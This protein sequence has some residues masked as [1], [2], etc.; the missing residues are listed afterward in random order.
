MYVCQ[1]WCQKKCNAANHLKYPT[2][3]FLGP[4]IEISYFLIFPLYFSEFPLYILAAQYQKEQVLNDNLNFFIFLLF[5]YCP[6]ATFK[7][8]PSVI[9]ENHTSQCHMRGPVFFT[10]KHK[11]RH[12][13][14]ANHTFIDSMSFVSLK[15]EGK[16]L[17]GG[18]VI[19]H[20]YSPTTRK[21]QLYYSFIEKF[22]QLFQNSSIQ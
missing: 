15:S 22:R 11:L 18:L 1:Y 6:N 16:K 10:F 3:I 21:K 14:L 19:G 8:C 2:Q 13:P 12:W 20:V 7:I 9:I 5:L 4:T 17:N